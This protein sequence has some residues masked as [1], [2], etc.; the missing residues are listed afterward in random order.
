MYTHTHTHTRIG[1]WVRNMMAYVVCG[2]VVTY[3]AEEVPYWKLQC[4]GNK[5]YQKIS[6]WMVNYGMFVGLCVCVCVHVYVYVDVHVNMY[7]C[8]CKCDD[9]KIYTYNY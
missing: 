8:M 9:V 3:I 5:H 7:V 2:M 1:R 6:L 4:I